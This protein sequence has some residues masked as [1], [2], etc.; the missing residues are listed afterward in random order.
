MESFSR[1]APKIFTHNTDAHWFMCDAIKQMGMKL[2]GWITYPY[3]SAGNVAKARWITGDEKYDP[4]K[5]TCVDD[6]LLAKANGVKTGYQFKRWGDNYH[7]TA[8][9]K[10]L[11]TAEDTRGWHRIDIQNRWILDESTKEKFRWFVKEKYQTLE[12]VNRVWGTNYT[13]FSEIDP[14]E[15]TYL[16]QGNPSY[17]EDDAVFNEWCRALEDLD[18]FRT[19]SRMEGYRTI[20]N[21]NR[22]LFD[23]VIGIR[24]EGGNW[25]CVVPYSTENQRFRHVYYSQRRVAA[26]PEEISKTGIV[27]VHSDY[28]TLPYSPWE[29][30][31]LTRGSVELGITPMHMIQCDRMRDVAINSHYGQ[32]YSVRYNLGEKANRGVYINTS[33]SLFGWFKATYENGGIP[34]VLWEDY[35]CDGYVTAMQQKEMKFFKQKLDEALNTPEGRAWQEDCQVDTKSAVSKSLGVNTFDPKYVASLIEKCKAN[36]K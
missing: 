1:E 15:G 10:V 12:E 13:D 31:E 5:I 17:V 9:G 8:D 30:A 25:T 33:M 28:C 16:D 32:D 35:L 27:A 21:I 36:R 34:G 26:V 14:E 24:T 22:D 2:E 11:I 7:V 3:D 23:G 20:L 19:S 4:G 18:R 6:P 29:V